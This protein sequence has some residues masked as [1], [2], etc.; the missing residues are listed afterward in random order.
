[1]DVVPSRPDASV[2]E[3]AT[4]YL[5][6][7]QGPYGEQGVSADVY[8]GPYDTYGTI[9]STAHR[10]LGLGPFLVDSIGT[11]GASKLL[12]VLAESMQC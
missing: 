11:R 8:Y 10:Q 9:V 6:Y 4:V 7:V 5:S 12:P 2:W 1:M 3:V